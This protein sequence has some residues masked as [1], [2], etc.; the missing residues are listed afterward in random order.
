MAA[1]P[2]GAVVLRERPRIT[3]ET[4]AAC[5]ALPEGASRCCASVLC[6]R[7]GAGTFGNAYAQFMGVRRF[8]P[9]D[10][11]PVRFVD[12][13]ELAY[14]AVRYR[15]VHD[16]WHVLF[17]CDTTVAGEVALKAVEAVQTGLPSTA[18]AALF[19]PLRLSRPRRAELA[20]TQ[21]PWALRAGAVATDLLCLRYEQHWAEPLPLLRARW[22]IA[23]APPFAHAGRRNTKASSKI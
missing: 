9:R 16:L 1:D 19:G 13:E 20:R 10:R 15:E 23:T 18:L 7:A 3:D 12:D 8:S 11:P 6:S 21:L 22:R 5:W 4:L 2:D 17:G 14:V